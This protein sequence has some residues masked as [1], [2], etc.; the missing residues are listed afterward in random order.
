MGKVPKVMLGPV[1]VVGLFVFMIF[2]A[3]AITK[4]DIGKQKAF[5]T[6]FG[7]WLAG[8]ILFFFFFFFIG[9]VDAEY[10]ESDNENV[11]FLSMCMIVVFAF[12]L[13][14][15][16]RYLT[17]KGVQSDY[18][19]AFLGLAILCGAWGFWM[20]GWASNNVF[21]QNFL[22][23]KHTEVDVGWLPFIGSGSRGLRFATETLAAI[24]GIILS[25]AL[26][27]I[28]AIYLMFILP[29]KKRRK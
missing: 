10:W 3:Y 23:G 9:V 19:L 7:T 1:A 15:W 24:I 4:F 16:A 29:K 20:L 28:A 25:V 26:L 21:G 27:F 12:L 8:A 22:R 17:L 5:K 11:Y 14:L 2:V 6:L 18:F 13:L